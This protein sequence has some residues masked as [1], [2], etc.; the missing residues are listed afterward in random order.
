MS[1][2]T[3]QLD[4]CASPTFTGCSCRTVLA[5]CW[6]MSGVPGE[7]G[8]S[9]ADS[10]RFSSC[11]CWSLSGLITSGRGSSSAIS[12][13]GASCKHKTSSLC[14]TGVLADM[15]G[16]CRSSSLRAPA[17]TARL[18][19]IS[20]S[21]AQQVKHAPRYA[22]LAALQEQSYGREL[23]AKPTGASARQDFTWACGLI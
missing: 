5:C 15:Q 9:A 10:S 21:A 14:H 1:G 7:G 19:L 12:S 11:W 18:Q 3:Q 16:A 4:P 22:L 8:P 20:W 17:A 13:T 6:G 2:S 23:L